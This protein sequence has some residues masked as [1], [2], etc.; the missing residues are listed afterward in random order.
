M[1]SKTRQTSRKRIKP[2][3]SLTPAQKSPGKLLHDA[4]ILLGAGLVQTLQH[5]GRRISIEAW[6]ILNLLW[7]EDNLA[8]FEIGARIGKDR[9]QT[10]RLIDSLARLGL[11][12]RK[13]I[14]EDRR[15]KRVVL[16]DVGRAAKT[17]LRRIAA[18]YL[19]DAF[20]GI[21]QEEYDVFI[22]CLQHLVDSLKPTNE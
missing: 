9:H 18:K 6:S 12:T 3:I 22:R 7:E 2:K 5:E 15:I 14:A 1:T 11:V 10:S 21:T 8:Q 17:S 13:P 20:S 19:E 4:N 16:T